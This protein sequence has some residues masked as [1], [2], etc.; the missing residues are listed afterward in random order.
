MKKFSTFK[1]SVLSPLNALAM[2]RTGHHF[3][4]RIEPEK[5][6]NIRVIQSKDFA[7]GPSVDISSLVPVVLES[8]KEDLIV[9]PG[10]IILR[11][12]GGINYPAA[13][14]NA[15]A[16]EALP[17][18]PLLLIRIH[19]KEILP[20]YLAWYLNQ[21][22]AQKILQEEAKGTFI[23]T[24]SKT[25]LS[26]LPIPVPSLKAQKD[27]VALSQLISE[28]NQLLMKIAAKRQ[29]LT[30]RFLLQYAE[31]DSFPE[32]AADLMLPASSVSQFSRP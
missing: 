13:I 6:G 23:P 8:P 24:V 4:E 16:F 17:V 27:I 31:E 15:I 21:S 5:E 2:I 19:S 3:R 32:T 12:R 11:T 22:S 26:K 9:Q 25:V 7:E 10:D 20:G 1:K 29:G 28:E 30:N 14:I 18:F